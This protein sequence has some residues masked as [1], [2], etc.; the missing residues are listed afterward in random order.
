[1][2]GLPRVCGIQTILMHACK[3]G[4]VDVEDI[5][6]EEARQRCAGNL[7]QRGQ[8]RVRECPVTLRAAPDCNN[9]G[10]CLKPVGLLTRIMFV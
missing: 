9:A 6:G 5:G 1:V 8:C 3:Y 10:I 4:Y 7:V 2:G